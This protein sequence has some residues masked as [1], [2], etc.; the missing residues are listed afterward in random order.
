MAVDAA[1]GRTALAQIQAGTTG[2]TDE[3]TLAGLLLLTKVSPPTLAKLAPDAT[4]AL[5]HHKGGGKRHHGGF[6]RRL[7][8]T[9]FADSQNSASKSSSL[10]PPPPPQTTPQPP[11]EYCQQI[12]DRVERDAEEEEHIQ[13]VMETENSETPLLSPMQSLGIHVISALCRSS[14]D[15]EKVRL[16]LARSLL[17]TLAELLQFQVLPAI[18]SDTANVC[19]NGSVESLFD[20]LHNLR[21][22]PLMKERIDGDKTFK[23]DIAE[24]TSGGREQR[25]QTTKSLCPNGK[26]SI[27][28]V[29]VLK[30]LKEHE[31]DLSKEPD[32]P[33]HLKNVAVDFILCD[34]TADD[35]LRGH[36]LA[37][38]LEAVAAAPGEMS[39]AISKE[40][41]GIGVVSEESAKLLQFFLDILLHWCCSCADSPEAHVD[42]AT[43]EALESGRFAALLRRLL[44]A[45]L[46][47]A[48]PEKLRDCAL[49]VIAVTMKGL[50]GQWCLERQ[51]KVDGAA[52]RTNV[53]RGSA[54]CL[55]LGVT[56]TEFRLLVDEALALHPLVPS[57]VPSIEGQASP[58]TE[59]GCRPLLAPKQREE[60]IQRVERMVPVCLRIIEDAIRFLCEDDGEE[61]EDL[62][63]AG[64]GEYEHEY[65]KPSGL[66]W[67]S[68]SSRSLLALQQTLHAVAQS[69][70]EFL[71]DARD[72]I[73]AGENSNTQLLHRISI[74]CC[75]CLGCWLAQETGVLQKELNDSKVFAFLLGLSRYSTLPA[76]LHSS[77]YED[78][79]ASFDSDDEDNERIIDGA[80]IN[81][82]EEA[83]LAPENSSNELSGA[84]DPLHTL[85]PALTNICA[86]DDGGFV[87]LL[88]F[89]DD[90]Q[91]VLEVITN[92]VLI[93]LESVADNL[94]SNDEPDQRAASLVWALGMLVSS[95]TG[96][97][98]GASQIISTGNGY[99]GRLIDHPCFMRIFPS[100]VRCSS[101]SSGDELG[102]ISLLLN[103][104][105]S[106]FLFI[107]MNTTDQHRDTIIA[108]QVLH[109]MAVSAVQSFLRRIEKTHWRK[110]PMLNLAR[111]AALS[112]QF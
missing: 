20:C 96:S 85:L 59:G 94:A 71:G 58:E 90:T 34:L 74:L 36:D 27:T 51:E 95:L 48:A 110:D 92:F 28:L 56:A 49:Q 47:G 2:G 9:R 16:V 21:V 69:I 72:T 111:K 67:A 100:L 106:L 102:M 98:G 13:T 54:I 99:H 19:G 52:S 76:P 87:R 61:P 6:L 23:I 53:D 75:R 66:G 78:D 77:P 93:E 10:P 18:T 104:A 70:I 112:W 108:D 31:Q 30:C 79:R 15:C 4:E 29:Q 38:L 42:A 33:N 65:D 22:K 8:L 37:S 55:F 89:T 84:N 86:E 82:A 24:E 17:P 1:V 50:G 44:M 103:H 14:P 80:P 109:K 39:G 43:K 88:E 5:L 105:V 57:I 46:H 62:E 3:A 7:L 73:R 83:S 101:K 12:S 35:R 97:S 45:A 64:G 40:S 41:G 107:E 68:M 26:L 63:E 11:R 60:R 81:A 91:N 25:K 32:S